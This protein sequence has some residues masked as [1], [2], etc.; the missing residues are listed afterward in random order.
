MVQQV[1]MHMEH[2]Q[3]RQTNMVMVDLKMMSSQLFEPS[4]MVDLTLYK[5]QHIIIAS[6]MKLI[7]A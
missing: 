7:R 5:L 2:H 1:P 6:Q 3:V 4:A